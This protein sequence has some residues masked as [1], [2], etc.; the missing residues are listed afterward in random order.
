V[1]RTA[2]LEQYYPIL[3]GRPRTRGTAEPFDVTADE[4]SDSLSSLRILFVC[5][6][7]E[8]GM[9]G[10]GDYTRRLAAEISARGQACSLLA[11][12]DQYVR[13]ATAC[14]V[15]EAGVTMPGLRLSAKDSWPERLRRAKRFCDEVAPD[16][17]SWQIVLYGF[18]PRGLSFGLGA[19]LRQISRGRRNE[20]MFHEIWIGEAEHASLKHKIVGK[21]QRL[22][23]KDLLRKL[24]P[25]VVHTHTPLYQHLLGAMGVQAIILPLFG[26]IPIAAAPDPEWLNEKARQSGVR[27]TLTDRDSW[28][29]FVLFGS[30]HPEWDGGDFCRR[31]S[32]AAECANKKCVLISIGRAGAFGER[33]LR[34]LQAHKS[35]SWRFLVLGQ[36][37]E[38]DISQALLTA[39]FGISPVPPENV[40]KSGTTAA[41]LEHGL[42]VIVTRPL[43]NYP[44]CPPEKL[45]VGMRNV[46]RNFD[47]ENAR[48][49]KMGSFLP[50]AAGQ[51]IEDLRRVDVKT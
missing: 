7:L 19:R 33:M 11:L 40:F 32:A 36:Q 24:Q 37:P 51:F 47:L 10:V 12:G 41:M 48:K 44:A 38:H 17:I 35:E 13:Q 15:T 29:I 45:L 46:V 21:L 28:W 22:I 43:V 2:V 30:I 5:N 49:S 6:C 27:W 3:P 8:P 31:A 18:D 20:I 42:P 14:D 4:F 9:D 26:N 23:V 25:L 1:L 34:D 39:D 16:W 50:S